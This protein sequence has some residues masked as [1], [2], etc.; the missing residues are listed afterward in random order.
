MTRTD[1][2]VAQRFLASQLKD[3][4]Q[5]LNLAEERL[6]EFK[7]RNLGV[8][9]GSGGDYYS[10]LE[11]EQTNLK[12]L[13]STYRQLT[14][15]R[16]ELANQLNSESPTVIQMGGT[17]L[18]PIDAQIAQ[19]QS[20]IDQLLLAY[21]DKHPQVVSLRESIARLEAEKAAGAKTP[22][23]SSGGQ[24]LDPAL[25][26]NMG[27]NPVYQ[28]LRMALSQSDAD[29][30]Q[31]RGQIADQEALIAELRARLD[32]IPEVEAEAARLNR[33]YQVN[34]GQYEALLQ[35]LEA[36]RISEQ[37]DQN[38]ESVKFRVIE[39]PVKPLVP[40]GPNRAAMN[41]LV[42]L[43]AIGAG[44]G[45]AILLS[46]L[47]PTFSSREVLAR[48][49][50]VPVLGTLTAVIANGLVPW[51][52]RESTRVAFAMSLLLAVYL[53]NVTLSDT[54]RRMLRVVVG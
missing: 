8:L 25:A 16:A 4:E 42:L 22:S 36:A 44:I 41:T 51:Y 15:R 37:A 9:P 7:Q 12:G 2:G 6:A 17:A 39:P 27:T 21:T 11:A 19:Y 54:L 18:D 29:M 47:R 23:S 31:V 1:S 30:A 45:L 38:A 50:G 32:A 3:Y 26:Q 10:R 46:Q 33:D 5:R 43:A 13:Q 24:T 53:L 40:S 34:K 48:V 49:T 52:R 35:R 20:Q 14:D 28:S